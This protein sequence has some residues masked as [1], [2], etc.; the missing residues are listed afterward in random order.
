M[1]TF[2]GIFQIQ[3][4][5]EMASVWFIKV[6]PHPYLL[7]AQPIWVLV[8]HWNSTGRVSVVHPIVDA[9]EEMDNKLTLCPSLSTLLENDM[10]GFK[11]L[12][13]ILL[14]EDKHVV[15]R[16]LYG[17]PFS[18]T[19]TA[20]LSFCALTVRTQ[21]STFFVFW[22][23]KL[24]TDPNLLSRSATPHDYAKSSLLSGYHTHTH[25]CRYMQHTRMSTTCKPYV[26]AS[27]YVGS[28]V[29]FRQ[30]N[31]ARIPKTIAH[32]LLHPPED[33]LIHT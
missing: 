9:Q 15:K 8:L 27:K 18:L 4:S 1:A 13:G 32:G 26:W 10:D 11:I 6:Q 24:C 29:L 5:M 33:V 20:S 21:C 23:Q 28:V 31:H 2:E 22:T 7:P 25:T 3:T 14:P 19:E 12:I 16:Q 30:S 17:G